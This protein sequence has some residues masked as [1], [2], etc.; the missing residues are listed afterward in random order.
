MLGPPRSTW[1]TRRSRT[2]ATRISIAACANRWPALYTARAFLPAS[3]TCLRPDNHRSEVSAVT[4]SRD[5]RST[6]P[7]GYKTGVAPLDVHGNLKD[8]APLD[9]Q[10]R[11][12]RRPNTVAIANAQD[13][14][15]AELLWGV[16]HASLKPKPPPQRRGRSPGSPAL[17]TQLPYC[18]MSQ[19][20]TAHRFLPDAAPSARHCVD[21]CA[22]PRP[23]CVYG[24]HILPPSCVQCVQRHV[25]ASRACLRRR[26][27]LSLMGSQHGHGHGHA[28]G[29]VTV[30]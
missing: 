21:T 11:V 12:S 1:A 27:A 15:V 26:A 2:A 30:T 8:Q 10:A 9:V 14:S 7:A 6:K 16:G 20:R 25:P 18:F 29:N 19:H 23:C 17:K 24:L 5:T 28:R 22:M 3:T 13:A 4:V